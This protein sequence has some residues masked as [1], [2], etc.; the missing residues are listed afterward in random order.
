MEKRKKKKSKKSKS[1]EKSSE[2]ET[3]SE[4]S[5]AAIAVEEDD[6]QKKRK[7]SHQASKS[8]TNQAKRSRSCNPLLSEITSTSE[9]VPMTNDD[10]LKSP[11]KNFDE[12]L[13]SK[14]SKSK[15]SKS[16][17]I[18]SNFEVEHMEAVESQESTVAENTT[19]VEEN[20]LIA[21]DSDQM[22]KRHTSTPKEKKNSEIGESTE[23]KT[24]KFS[25]KKIFTDQGGI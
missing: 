13:K 16:S 4:E 6:C 21:R 3:S 20:T 23:E 11:A 19:N 24:C 9:Q 25:F 10:L 7:Y 8:V 17:I 2:R 15:K 22:K 1:I 18:S 14:K 12:G 5:S